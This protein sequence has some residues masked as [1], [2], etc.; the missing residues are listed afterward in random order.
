M[1]RRATH[2]PI[3]PPLE[4]HAETPLYRQVYEGLRQAMLEGRLR[5]GEPL[6]ST[7]TLAR[8]LGVSRNTV[9]LAFDQ[10]GAEGYIEG[11]ARSATRVAHHMPNELSAPRDNT[12]QRSPSKR[13]L[14]LRRPTGQPREPVPARQSWA[15]AVGVPA[16][17]AFPRETWARLLVRRARRFSAIN[18]HYQ[19]PR[20][21]PALREAIAV[22][23]GA[24]RGLRCSPEQVIVTSG[25]QQALDLAARVLLDPGERV[26]LEEPGYIGAQRAFLGAGLEIVPVPVDTEG[27][28]ISLGVRRAP[29]ARLVYVTPSH[30]FPLGYTLSLPRRL[31]L[32][33]WAR[34][35]D[36]WVLEDDYDSEFCY[37]GRPLTSLAGLDRDG[38][39]IYVGTFSKVMFPGL[40]LGYLVVPPDLVESFALALLA[41]STHAPVLEQ[42]ALTDFII[43]GHFARHVKTMR[44]LYAERQ[45]RLL[46]LARAELGG[47]LELEPSEAG[48]HLVGW[49]PD[50]TH[51]LEA[52]RAAHRA[53]V[54]HEP[55]SAFCLE[56][57]P[58]AGLMLGYAAVTDDAMRNAVRQL[59]HVLQDETP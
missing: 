21:F 50:G 18:M 15:F 56:P 38:R 8:D 13:N 47:L 42:A 2:T 19:Q 20:G 12:Q 52:S 46:E 31:A 40:R 30:Q 7:R 14:R 9:L 51:E 45:S 1:K 25:S 44:A 58:R 33:E 57:F 55:V 48:M 32:L 34:S 3:T 35:T 54:L 41:S 29:D 59:V 23:L 11:A 49:L 26:W 16:L 6:P 24:T 39:V 5:S 10:L 36:A 43:E 17:D 37:A 22:Y 4:P 53:G 28:Q 27:I